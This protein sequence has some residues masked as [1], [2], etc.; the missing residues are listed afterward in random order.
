[1]VIL[2]PDPD[3]FPTLVSFVECCGP[4]LGMRGLSS[5]QDLVE[6]WKGKTSERVWTVCY[7]QTPRQVSVEIDLGYCVLIRCQ[8]GTGYGISMSGDMSRS[9]GTDEIDLAALLV[10]KRSTPPG[11]T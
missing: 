2:L 5:N 9:R 8:A 10:I 6:R 1:M 11:S 7:A 4:D 3:V